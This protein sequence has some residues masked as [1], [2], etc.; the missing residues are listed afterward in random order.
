[1]SDDSFGFAPPP[2]DAD[3]ALQRLQRDLRELGLSEREGA[4][5]RRGLRIAMLRRAAGSG[6]LDAA[7][8]TQPARSP[9]WKTRQ[10]HDAA[11]VRSFLADL[12]RQLAAWSD[13]DD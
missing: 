5:E 3:A 9:Q 7:I 10:I 8:A 2:F 13:R 4:F 6:V 1:M 11:G 12:K